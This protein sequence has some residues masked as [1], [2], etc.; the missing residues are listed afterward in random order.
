MGCHRKLPMLKHAHAHRLR[1]WGN[2]VEAMGGEKP[3]AHLREIR[4]FLCRL[5]VARQL[6]CGLR[7]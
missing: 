4:S 1:M 2:S 3:F 5:P 7:A 6:L